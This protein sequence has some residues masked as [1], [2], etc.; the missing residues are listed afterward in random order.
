MRVPSL[1]SAVADSIVKSVGVPTVLTCGGKNA[2]KSTFGRYLV[3]RLLSERRC[4]VAFLETD[5]GQCEFTPPGLVSLN[6]LAPGKGALLGPSPTHL[7]TPIMS[8][9]AGDVTPKTRP[10]LYMDSVRALLDEYT[11]MAPQ[12]E[13]FGGM[14]LVINTHGW[15]KGMGLDLM[16]AI[17]THARPAHIVKFE[18]RNPNRRF[19]TPFATPCGP[20]TVPGNAAGLS[21]SSASTPSHSD[22][23]K[24]HIL[25]PFA[26]A[27][28]SLSSKSQDGPPRP[29]AAFLRTMKLKNYFV[30]DAVKWSDEVEKADGGDIGEEDDD[31]LNDDDD[32]LKD[33]DGD[34]G[35][36]RKRNIT[37]SKKMKRKQ[38][39]KQRKSQGSGKNW[40]CRRRRQK[41][42]NS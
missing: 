27:F 4:P 11:K 2:G 7:T 30:S 28:P 24:V 33:S 6:V 38:D 25:S 1:W 19:P 34:D 32:D 10:N 9:F 39:L 16:R 14:P 31:S 13:E 41:N 8:F 35:A 20:S 18:S 36:N 37:L 3:N 40:R 22:E 23:Q 26:E 21:L 12:Y 42:T 15:V 29:S 5:V 17:A